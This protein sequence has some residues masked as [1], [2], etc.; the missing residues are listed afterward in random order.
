MKEQPIKFTDAERRHLLRLLHDAADE[1]S[2]YGNHRHYWS[3][4]WRLVEKLEP[5]VE[6][7]K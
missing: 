4:H 7:A 2:Y 5:A 1:G 3:R 6:E